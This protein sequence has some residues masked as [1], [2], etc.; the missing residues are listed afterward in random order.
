MELTPELYEEEAEFCELWD[1]RETR[2]QAKEVAGRFV[3]N[4]PELEVMFGH[5]NLEQMV[6][7]VDFYRE[8]GRTADL[9]A[10]KMWI[11]A[12]FEP[13]KIGG[14]AA[15]QTPMRRRK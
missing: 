6:E 12:M 10:A 7:Q 8:K 15:I 1:N 3:D 13:Q 4:H 11:Q 2:A 9:I 5:L 14:Q